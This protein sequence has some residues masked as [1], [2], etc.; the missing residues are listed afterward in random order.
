MKKI[1]IHRTTPKK[2][3]FGNRKRIKCAIQYEQ[4]SINQVI[5]NTL[6]S[7][8]INDFTPLKKL[9]NGDYRGACPFCYKGGKTNMT[10][11][12]V[13]DRLNRFKC[14]SCGIGGLNSVGFLLRYFNQPFDF[15]IRYVN[16]KYHNNY[17][18]LIEKPVVMKKQS[19]IDETDLLPF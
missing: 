13:S 2:Y 7:G 9:K 17:Y 18:V 15:V 8:V 16:Y 11:L 6:L 19:L 3:Y 1:F 5:Y 4:A 10:Y 12:R 14:F